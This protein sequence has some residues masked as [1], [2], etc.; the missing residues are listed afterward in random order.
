MICIHLK[1]SQ[2]SVQVLNINELYTESSYISLSGTS[3][4]FHCPFTTTSNFTC[5]SVCVF[6]LEYYYWVRISWCLGIRK[7]LIFY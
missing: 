7:I 4:K 2:M 6:A 5:Y 3:Y 1:F